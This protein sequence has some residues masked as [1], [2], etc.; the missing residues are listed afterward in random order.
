MVQTIHVRMKEHSFPTLS[1]MSAEFTA[2]RTALLPAI[3]ATLAEQ[4]FSTSWPEPDTLRVDPVWSFLDVCTVL[5]R[6][7]FTL[8]GAMYF[9]YYFLFFTKPV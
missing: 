9:R 6:H 3:E 7:G 2:S 1:G 8:G 4:N 5:G